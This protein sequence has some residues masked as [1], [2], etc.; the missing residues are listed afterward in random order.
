M[1]KTLHAILSLLD[2]EVPLVCLEKARKLSRTMSERG[3]RGLLLIG[4]PNAPLLE[5]PVGTDKAGVAVV[6][7]LNPVA[8]LEE[9][10]I[11][12]ESRAM[13]ALYDNSRL[14]PFIEIVARFL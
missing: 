2:R 5:V 1:H 7:G 3:I 10:G 14:V 13:S 9:Q 11:P 8:A 6:G 4:S 12:T